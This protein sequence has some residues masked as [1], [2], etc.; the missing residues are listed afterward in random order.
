ME[1]IGNVTYIIEKA[2]IYNLQMLA[3]KPFEICRDRLLL[4]LLPT[5]AEFTPKKFDK[6]RGEKR[7]EKEIF[8]TGKALV[9]RHM[10][11]IIII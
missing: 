7:K 6:R 8:I 9:Y 3:Q 5:I 4:V 11:L 2:A 1:Q 10:T